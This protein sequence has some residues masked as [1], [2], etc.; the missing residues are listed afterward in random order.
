MGRLMVLDTCAVLWIAFNRE[1]FTKQTL[2]LI[3]TCENLIISTMSFWEIGVKIK[4][5]KLIIPMELTEFIHLFS[6]NHNISIVAPGI[7]IILRTLDLPWA[8]NDPVDRI[9][10]ATAIKYDMK[11]VSGDAT[12]GE[13][14][15]E[16]IV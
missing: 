15:R 2:G 8:H 7:D 13:F 12:I 16:T 5:K 1:K 9:V 10:V 14:Y 3:D 4:K 6:S 11:L